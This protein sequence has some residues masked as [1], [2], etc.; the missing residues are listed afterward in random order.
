VGAALAQLPRR[1]SARANIS[2]SFGSFP[3]VSSV[4][5]FSVQAI[6]A[7]RAGQPLP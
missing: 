2:A 4:K 1:S 5:R 7:R 6:A 3:E